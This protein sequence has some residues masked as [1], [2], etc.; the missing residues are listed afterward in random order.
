MQQL[1]DRLLVS[2]VLLTSAAYALFALGPEGAS[3]AHGRIVRRSR[4]TGVGNSGI[5]RTAAAAQREPRQQDAE[6]LRR[7]R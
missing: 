7:L 2:L 1:I 5:A 4:G 6:Q 3:Q